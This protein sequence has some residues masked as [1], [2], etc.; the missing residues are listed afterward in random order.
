MFFW[1]MCR[2]RVFIDATHASEDTEM[3][4]EVFTR[5]V[6]DK[7]TMIKNY[8][9][10][11]QIEAMFTYKCEDVRRVK[12]PMRRIMESTMFL[13]KAMGPS[14]VAVYVAIGARNVLYG[15]LQLGLFLATINV[16]RHLCDAFAEFFQLSM[17]IC[18]TFPYFINLIKLFNLKSELPEVRTHDL[19][20]ANMTMT[21]RAEVS[22]KASSSLPRVDLLDI[23][24]SNLSF[25]YDGEDKLFKN[26]NF[27]CPQGKICAVQ[28]RTGSGRKTVLELLSENRLPQEGVLFVPSH[29]KIIYVSTETTFLN[30]SV[31]KNLTFGN[32]KG[33]DPFRAEKI[34]Q[35]FGRDKLIR[36]CQSE[37]TEEKASLYKFKKPMS[38]EAVLKEANEE[39]SNSTGADTI[40]KLRESEKADVHIMRALLLNP[41]VLV[42]HRPF[43]HFHA[44]VDFQHVEQAMIGHRN[45]RGFMLPQHQKHVR[46]P[47]TVFYTADA[48]WM[49]NFA[50]LVWHLPHKPGGECRQYCPEVKAVVKDNFF[51]KSIPPSDFVQKSTSPSDFLGTSEAASEE[52]N[53]AKPDSWMSL[54]SQTQEKQEFAYHRNHPRTM[55]RLDSWL[56]QLW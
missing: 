36:L 13:P 29:L 39:S 42:M 24:L 10:R 55:C 53:A 2:Y 28:G 43:A 48:P 51:E 18:G 30:L 15:N 52:Q 49:L 12:I 27:S 20:K 31:W 50:D 56:P 44:Y 41:E 37:L 23:E 19:K 11:T 46:R 32:W 3:A 26:L 6:L 33:T 34:L 21:R 47:R 38:E 22:Q 17:D 9:Q 45:D 5:D 35:Y 7:R 16:F 40:M 14:L 4:L 8:R 25:G 54:G 1:G